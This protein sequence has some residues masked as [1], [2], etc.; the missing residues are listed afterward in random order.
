MEDVN[1][2]LAKEDGGAGYDAAFNKL[3]REEVM[4]LLSDVAKLRI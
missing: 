3:T 1:N 2:V 4:T